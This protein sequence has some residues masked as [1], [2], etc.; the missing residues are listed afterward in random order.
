MSLGL[1]LSRITPAQEVT[2]ERPGFGVFIRLFR[3]RLAR[4]SLGV[5]ILGVAD[6]KQQEAIDWLQRRI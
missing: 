2:H 3:Q 5:E 6:H 1:N 4:E